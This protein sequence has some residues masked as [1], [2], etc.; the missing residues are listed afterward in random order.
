MSPSNP[1]PTMSKNLRPATNPTSTRTGVPSAIDLGQLVRVS[2]QAKMLR[3]QVFGSGRQYRERDHGLL[4]DQG[5]HRTIAPHGHQ[6][7][8]MGVAGGA[9][10]Q[11]GPFFRGPG[12]L[13]E[14]TDSPQRAS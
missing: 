14:E 5:G 10:D 8:A 4:V 13:L 6:A 11:R 12:N 3:D 7:T 1:K 2:A 9:L